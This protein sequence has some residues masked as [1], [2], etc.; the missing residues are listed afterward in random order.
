MTYIE[1]FDQAIL[2]RI[3]NMNNEGSTYDRRGLLAHLERNFKIDWNGIHGINHWLRVHCFGMQIGMRSGA[4]LA[5]VDLFA[6]LHDCCRIAE[7]LDPLHGER[8]A[9]FAYRLNGTFYTLS[10]PQLDQLCTAIRFH[11]DG[12]IHSDP[13]IQ[14][15]WDGDRLDLGRVGIQP[16]PD[17]LSSHAKQFIEEA[18]PAF[19]DI[20]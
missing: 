5:V 15:C 11:S 7:R 10:E 4:D 13:T 1:S 3:S 14:S 12:W 16:H 18:S 19:S 6:Y 9:E 20:N 17:F 2:S 8:G